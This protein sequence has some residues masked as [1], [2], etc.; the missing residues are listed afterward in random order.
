MTVHAPVLRA[1]RAPVIAPPRLALAPLAA[2]RWRSAADM[3]RFRAETRPAELLERPAIVA[4]FGKRVVA[5]VADAPAAH[6]I[7]GPH[8]ASFP[9]A[10][11]Q[12]ALGRAAFGPGI[13]GVGGACNARQRQALS[14]ATAGGRGRALGDI[15]AEAA[16]DA[17]A[18]WRRAGR[19]DL[20]REMSAL[21]LQIVWASLFGD[22]RWHGADPAVDAA[23]D[24]LRA[25]RV[26]DFVASGQVMRDLA[27]HFEDS[28]RWR[29]TPPDNPFHAIACQDGLAGDA[30]LSRAEL[31]ANAA[32]FAGS[33]HVTTGL[34][35]AWTAWLLA[36]H[37]AD[38]DRV[39]DEIGGQGAGRSPWLRAAMSEALRLF[40]PGA[41][42]M[43]D[44][45]APLRAGDQDIPAGALLLVS[46]YALHRGPA[47]WAAPDD[48]SPGRFGP[49]AARPEP[50]AY[51]PF[52]GGADGC[53]GAGSAWA[54]ALPV[55][56]RVFARLRLSPGPDAAATGLA[57]GI[58]IYPDR[59]LTV[60][61]APR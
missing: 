42:T 6:R 1:G 29:M 8:Q 37:P 38:Q 47:R 4:R 16:E 55:L 31:R 46:I 39:A 41:E 20:Y 32:V 59:P 21:A 50:G 33:G 3:I 56:R 35:M 45:R 2:M 48:F 36:G 49:G 7:L 28:G 11:L 23:S 19:I 57:P 51:L 13:S 53:P 34:C 52:S 5:L 24:R 44:A 58:C 40:P 61:V 27:R 30:P 43:R 60:E 14:W 17:V 18:R 54:E 25:C 12:S 15:A 26:D 10:Q 22:E 9:K